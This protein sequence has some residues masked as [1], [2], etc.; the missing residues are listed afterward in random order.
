MDKIYRQ[1]NI[2][3]KSV[4]IE[5]NLKPI[6][7]GNSWIIKFGEATGH[8]HLL[9][10]E[11]ETSFKIFE[12]KKGQKYLQMTG[13]G[14]LTHEQHKTIKVLPDFYVIGIEKEWDYF[15]NEIK[16]IID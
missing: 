13:K 10:V 14:I 3:L 6:F 11:P 4:K 8:K 1:G 9:T 15:E 5:Y 16:Q 12:D 7:E 2:M